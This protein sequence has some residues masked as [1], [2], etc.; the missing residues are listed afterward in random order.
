MTVPVDKAAMMEWLAEPGDHAVDAPLVCVLTRFGLRGPQH[1]LATYRDYRRVV[2]EAGRQGGPGLL[3]SAFLVENP[4]TCYSLSIW[5]D[6]NAIGQF[7]A[8]VPAHVHA[9]NEVFGRLSFDEARGPELWSTKWR[10][11]S[12]SHNL[13]WDDFDL[14]GLL[15]AARAAPTAC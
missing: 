7:G 6:L 12:V 13:N 10:L 5:R 14:R 4:V 2:G 11:L 9:G 1:L 8:N 3:R 15:V